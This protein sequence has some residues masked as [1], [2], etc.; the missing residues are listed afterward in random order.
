MHKMY[1]AECNVSK[2]KP[3]DGLGGLGAYGLGA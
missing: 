1:M 2:D 3:C